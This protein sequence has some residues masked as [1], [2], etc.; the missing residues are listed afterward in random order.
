MHQ[1]T[2]DLDT[3]YSKVSLTV[4]LYTIAIGILPL[5][6]G[7]LADFIGRKKTAII[8]LIIFEASCVGCLLAPEINSLIVFRIIQGIGNHAFPFKS[9]TTGIAAV[10]IVAT[11]TIT[12]TWTPDK[13]GLA[14]GLCAVPLLV[15]PVIGPVIGG[16]IANAW[17]WRATFV[18]LLIIG[19]LA[20]ITAIFVFQETLPYHVFE[21]KVKKEQPQAINPFEKPSFLAPWKPLQFYAIPS[22]AILSLG[23]GLCFTG[24]CMNF[25]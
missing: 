16:I 5:L 4:A 10:L 9:H 22:V 1:I 23:M 6:W 7:P 11:S 21:T 17:S 2:T 15:G 14:L 3:S 25:H 8:S 18:V 19:G 20:I 24:F 12:D 13:R